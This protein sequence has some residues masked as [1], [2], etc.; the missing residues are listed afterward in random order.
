ML[1]TV[2]DMHE[3]LKYAVVER[4]RRFL[5]ERIPEGV[6]EIRQ[7]SDRYLDGTRLR[8][9][10]V[11]GP[12]GAVTRK[13]GQKIRLEDGPGAIACTS[14]YLDDVEWKLL[15]ALPGRTLRKTR[16]IIKRDGLCLAIDEL[17]DGTLIAEIDDGDSEPLTPDWLNVVREVSAD[18]DWI[19]ASLAR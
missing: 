4:E 7:I 19:G 11:I 13:L 2:T 5:V 12:D 6:T 17:E 14:L 1:D 9:R 18:E 8:L 10:E 16:H 3:P 15:R